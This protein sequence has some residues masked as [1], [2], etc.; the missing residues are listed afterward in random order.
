MI[1][2]SI[3]H[4]WVKMYMARNNSSDVNGVNRTGTPDGEGVAQIRVHQA[5]NA[6]TNIKYIYS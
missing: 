1:F 6:L 4:L 5:W 2:R 3:P